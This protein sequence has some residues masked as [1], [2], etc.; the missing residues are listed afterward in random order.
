MSIIPK[1][2]KGEFKNVDINGEFIKDVPIVLH[3]FEDVLDPS[4]YVE[5]YQHMINIIAGG[6]KG[7]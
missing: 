7:K 5:T 4:T 3:P 6:L 2:Y 1:I